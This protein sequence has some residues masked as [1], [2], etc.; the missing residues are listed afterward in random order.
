MAHDEN[1]HGKM[2]GKAATVAAKAAPL[3]AVANATAPLKKRSALG[4]VSN[5]QVQPV[6]L[7]FFAFFVNIF[8]DRF[9]KLKFNDALC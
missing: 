9:K 7:F 2:A 5:V 6:I 1:A 3:K 4:D 8:G